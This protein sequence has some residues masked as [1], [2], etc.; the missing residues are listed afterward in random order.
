MPPSDSD[1]EFFKDAQVDIAVPED[2]QADL[3]QII[4]D[5]DSRT[6][7]PRGRSP[8]LPIRSRELLFFGM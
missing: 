4:Q 8:L 2:G 7:L 1:R 5:G 3:E 6:P